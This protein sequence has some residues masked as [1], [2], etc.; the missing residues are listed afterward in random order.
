MLHASKSEYIRD[1]SQRERRLFSRYK[2]HIAEEMNIRIATSIASEITLRM[3]VC[4]SVYAKW[5]A[6]TEGI[7]FGTNLK[8]CFAI[9]V[10][11][12][13]NWSNIT[14][15]HAFFLAFSRFQALDDLKNC[16]LGFQ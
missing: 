9:F 2:F 12:S 6:K 5:S 8:I 13:F 10:F 3:G 14:F 1:N 11:N 15:L 4:R 7:Y 16:Q